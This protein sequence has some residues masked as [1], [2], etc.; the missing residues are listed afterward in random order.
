MNYFNQ[1]EIY[2]HI[3][4]ILESFPGTID[5]EELPRMRDS[6]NIYTKW[7]GY[8]LH[9]DTAGSMNGSALFKICTDLNDGAISLHFMGNKSVVDMY[10]ESF[11][12]D[13][14]LDR[15][16]VRDA[17]QDLLKHWES[18]RGGPC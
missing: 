6:D 4:E 5:V 18:D 10:E 17:V 14:E 7:E 15:Q 9:L 8:R 3:G 2:K 12:P 16:M 13:C 1:A 11:D